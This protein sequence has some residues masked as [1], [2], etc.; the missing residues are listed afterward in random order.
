V[1]GVALAE[2]SAD[3]MGAGAPPLFNNLTECGKRNASTR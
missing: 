1:M 3:R 2:R